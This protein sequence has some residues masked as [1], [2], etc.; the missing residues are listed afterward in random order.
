MKKIFC[1][2]ILAAMTFG[3]TGCYKDKGNYDYTDIGNVVVTVSSGIHTYLVQMG[4][5]LIIPVTVTSDVP[6]SELKYMWEIFDENSRFREFGEGRDFD[7]IIRPD[8]YFP[9]FGSYSVRL[10][11]SREIDGHTHS[12]YSSLI[13]ITISGGDLGLM[14]LHGND[15]ESDI[16]I[17]MDRHFLVSANAQIEER[18]VYNSYSSVN[19]AKIPGRGVFIIQQHM[20]GGVVPI[21]T[22]NIFIRTDQA[23]LFAGAEGMVKKG[24]YMDLFYSTPTSP[25]LN[26]GNLQKIQFYNNNNRCVIDDGVLFV[27][28]GLA[29]SRFSIPKVFTGRP[30]L[31]ASKHSFIVNQNLQGLIFDENT[32]GFIRASLTTV[33]EVAPTIIN[34]AG[35]GP[36]NPANM[37]ADLLYLDNIG[38]GASGNHLGVFQEDDGTIFL[39]EINFNAANT[40]DA[41]AFAVAKYNISRLPEFE[42][43][44]FHAVGANS[45]TCYYATSTAV[46]QYA[47][48]RES[49]TSDARKLMVGAEQVPFTGEITMMKILKSPVFTGISAYHRANRMMLVGTYENGVGTLHA[50][51]IDNMT[52]QAESHRTFTGFGRIYDVNLKS[53]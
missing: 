42:S 31:K 39:G 40:S 2:M 48:L 47:V 4:Q 53:M 49:G 24:D 45:S 32:R 11:V 23:A 43:A 16:G 37:Q 22:C 46:Y 19:G 10:R 30:N 9:T 25:S 17:I 8:N 7:F 51:M 35:W 44:K 5:H 34:S 41:N 13:T 33:G 26:N 20:T 3:S 38:I 52:G 29:N 28:T 15:T 1:Y 12:M 50:I 14:V 18:I 36:F 21:E 6:E 27:S